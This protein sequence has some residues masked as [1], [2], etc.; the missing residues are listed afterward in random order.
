MNKKKEDKKVDKE[1][2]KDFQDQTK[3]FLKDIKSRAG[4]LAKTIEKEAAYGSKASMVKVEQLSLEKDRK[5][6][7]CEL[8]EKAYSLLKKEEI[9]AP[10][11]EELAEKIEKIDYKIRG[12]K[13][14][15]TK[16]KKKKKK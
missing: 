15:L 16:L 12:K 6:A 7:V 9:E 3:E 8:G 2:K 10:Q 11:L 1:K 14:Q 13:A 4:K 5:N